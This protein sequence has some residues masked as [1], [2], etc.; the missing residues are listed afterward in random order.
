MWVAGSYTPPSEAVTKTAL[1]GSGSTTLMFWTP[2]KPRPLRP[3]FSEEPFQRMPTLL[4]LVW[5]ICW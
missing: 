2:T 4:G 3:F 1:A 5:S